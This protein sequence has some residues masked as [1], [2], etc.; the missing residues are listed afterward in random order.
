LYWEKD[1]ETLPRE[2][3]YELQK[4]RLQRTVQNA[5]RTPFY[6]RL[7]TREGINPEKI[8][9][10][11]DLRHIPFTTKEDL[12]QGFPFDFLAVPLEEVVR[13]HSSSGTTG[14]PTVVYH[15]NCLLYTSPSPRD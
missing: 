8:R 10:P 2:E 1:V 15:T 3:L 5:M 9:T 7:F 6:R 14:T 11:E 12:R 13:L 4:Q